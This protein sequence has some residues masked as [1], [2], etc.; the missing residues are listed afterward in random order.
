M[1]EIKRNDKH[2]YFING[3]K[4]P[5]VTQILR[6]GGVINN[7]W[8]TPESRERGSNVHT[9]CE[10]LDCGTLD[11]K[12]IYAGYSGYIEAYRDFLKTCNPQWEL[13]ENKVYNAEY[14]YCGTLDRYGY[15]FNGE[16]W[17]ID[18]K[19]GSESRATE[20]QLSAYLKA[21]G[22]DI[23]KCN[24]GAL[25]LRK[26]GKWKLIPCQLHTG[27]AGFMEAYKIYSINERG[28]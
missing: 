10:Y 24:L 21:L 17:L 14:D 28:F 5:S 27:W 15:L 3:V 1:L 11:E 12:S 13:I 9:I 18:I 19:S 2:E 7:A 23:K 20:M 8:F 26:N 25:H 6:G 4:K 16:Q 22:G